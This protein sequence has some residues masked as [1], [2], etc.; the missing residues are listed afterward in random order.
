MVRIFCKN[1]TGGI[2]IAFYNVENSWTYE[3]WKGKEKGSDFKQSE[4]RK[5]YPVDIDWKSSKNVIHL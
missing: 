4:K 2:I 1:L 5:T 3:G